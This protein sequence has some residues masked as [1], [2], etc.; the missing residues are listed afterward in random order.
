MTLNPLTI[1]RRAFRNA[2]ANGIT[3]FIQEMAT[4]DAIQVQL[5]QILSPKL[6]AIANG[7][8]SSPPETAAAADEEPVKGK[9]K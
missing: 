5:G 3:D 7:N 8:G 4:D 6:A 1:V 9:R 2:A